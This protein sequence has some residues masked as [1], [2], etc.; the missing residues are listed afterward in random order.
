MPGHAEG[1]AATFDKADKAKGQGVSGPGWKNPTHK[2][3]HLDG[4]SGHCC[5]VSS[6]FS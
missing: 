5:T 4:S 2:T 6:Q 3:T 1:Q